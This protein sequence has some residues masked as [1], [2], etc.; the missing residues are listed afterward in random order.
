MRDN[1]TLFPYKIVSEVSERLLSLAIRLELFPFHTKSK[2]IGH[3][4]WLSINLQWYFDFIQHRKNMIILGWLS[5][6]NLFSAL[7]Y[8][9]QFR[10][11]SN[12][13][14]SPV[15]SLLNHWESHRFGKERSSTFRNVEDTLWQATLYTFDCCRVHMILQSKPEFPSSAQQSVILPGWW[16]CM[17]IG[18]QTGTWVHH[19]TFMNIELIFLHGGYRLNILR[20][21]PGNIN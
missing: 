4:S 20:S 2:N 17:V 15:N 10:K 11:L 21:H 7:N 6:P 3:V 5:C 1:I 19:K 18:A 16:K 13:L 9:E 12:Q 8:F 14:Y